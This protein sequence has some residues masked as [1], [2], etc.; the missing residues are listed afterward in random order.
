MKF[1]G[2]LALQGDVSEHVY[3]IKKAAEKLKIA[4]AVKEVKYPVEIKK[5]DALV[6]PGGE[7]TTMGKLLQKHK[8]FDIIK[9]RI[10]GGMPVL[11]TC[12]G[13][14]LMAEEGDISVE[15]TKQPLFGLM[16]YHIDRNAF[17]RQRE[18]FEAEL[19]IPVLGKQKFHAVFIRAP[20]VSKTWG[21]A[22]VLAKYEGKIVLVQQAK[23]LACAFHPELT[24]D[25]RLQEYFLKLI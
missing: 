10:I 8:V 15:K 13:M 18:S 16:H 22:K 19:E 12:A 6:L 11:A 24:E 14:I 21:N 7:S 5:I 17:G 9:E 2:V 25:T 23:M 1:I 3:A 20:A 4:C